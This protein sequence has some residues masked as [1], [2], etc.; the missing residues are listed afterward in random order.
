K[1]DQ[2]I[3]VFSDKIKVSPSAYCQFLNELQTVLLPYYDIIVVGN[4]ED[5]V[6]IK[7]LKFLRNNYRPDVSLLLIPADKTTEEYKELEREIWFIK[8]YKQIQNKTTIYLCENYNCNTPITE[9]EELFELL[10]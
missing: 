6:T 7:I 9:P 10:K 8:D 5:R 2:M 1:A 4:K 3:H